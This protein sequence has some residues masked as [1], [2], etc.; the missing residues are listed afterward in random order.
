M[1]FIRECVH[2]SL[3]MPLRP[4]A[5]MQSGVASP[6]SLRLQYHPTQ[7]WR[8]TGGENGSALAQSVWAELVGGP[9]L[10]LPIPAQGW[11]SEEETGRP[12]NR[13]KASLPIPLTTRSESYSDCLTAGIGPS[14]S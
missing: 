8:F 10:M 3:T 12:G 2:N 14:S 11:K 1:A 13:V 4:I 7:Q 5:A 9:E 6:Q